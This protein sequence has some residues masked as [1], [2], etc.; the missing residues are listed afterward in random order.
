MKNLLDEIAKDF[1]SQSHGSSDYGKDEVYVRGDGDEFFVPHSYLQKKHAGNSDLE[2]LQSEGY[3]LS[4]LDFLELDQF[5][6][7]YKTQF[8]K[9][10]TQKQKKAIKN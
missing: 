1:S 3:V 6:V 4:S 2:K 8:N 10:L 5:D 9:K 7:W